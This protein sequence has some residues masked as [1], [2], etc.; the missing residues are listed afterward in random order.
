MAEDEW[1]QLPPLTKSEILSVGAGLEMLR[2]V[3]LQKTR[4][5]KK[6]NPTVDEDSQARA[7]RACL[8]CYAK[9]D[10]LTKD[11]RDRVNTR[12]TTLD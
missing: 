3:L 4:Y 10:P 8:S 12:Q 11:L 7:L 6:F 5:L 1:Y 9:V 2:D